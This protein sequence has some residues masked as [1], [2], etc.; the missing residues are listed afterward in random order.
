MWILLMIKGAAWWSRVVQNVK[1]HF[2][3]KNARIVI[4]PGH[5]A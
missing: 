1:V 2:R 3:I 4:Q 5:L